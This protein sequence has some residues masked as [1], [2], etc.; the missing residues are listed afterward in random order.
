MTNSWD[1][2]S[3]ASWYDTILDKNEYEKNAKFVSRQLKK[4]N[5]KT[6]LELAC[7]SGLYLFPLKKDG[8][9]IEGLDI[10][11]KMLNTARKRSEIIKL[12][13][14][15]MTKFRINKR[16]DA[17]LILNSGLVLLPRHS[18]IDKTIKRCQTHLNET[19]ILMIDLPN[20]K[21]EIKES[22]FTQ[23]HEK[24]RIHNGQLDVIFRDH[25][26]KNKWISEWFGFIKQGN[27]FTQFKE[28]YE[29]LIYS[30]QKIE[31]SLKNQGFKILKIFGS[32][33]GGKFAYDNSW[34]RV[35]LCQKK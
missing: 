30:P 2:L 33:R 20:H 5:V 25:R 10:S 18:L 26:K 13:K 3:S 24:Y 34:R 17:I 14:Q 6:V 21:K 11:K 9:N 15:D 22:N 19:G 27:K 8:F 4:F 29:E 35:Y 31:A 32:R 1:F 16:Y 28:Y 7:G 23:N 12:Y